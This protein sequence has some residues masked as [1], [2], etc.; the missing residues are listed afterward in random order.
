[1]STQEAEYDHQITN[2][3]PKPFLLDDLIQILY[4]YLTNRECIAFHLVNKSIKY[5]LRV[6]PKR[7]K[8]GNEIAWKKHVNPIRTLSNMVRYFPYSK[9]LVFTN[10]STE[11]IT[12]ED[13]IS[14]AS[15]YPDV[16]ELI[17]GNCKIPYVTNLHE[18]VSTY[19]PTRNNRRR[20]ED[21]NANTHN[22]DFHYNA[23]RNAFVQDSQI[24]VTFAKRMKHLQ[25]LTLMNIGGDITS[26][27]SVLVLSCTR[28]R[29]LKLGNDLLRCECGWEMLAKAFCA[30]RVLEKFSFDGHIFHHQ[31]RD[32]PLEFDL[33]DD[34]TNIK[35]L[36]IGGRLTS[37]MI[38]DAAT[39]FHNLTHLCLGRVSDMTIRALID[40]YDGFDVNLISLSLTARLSPSLSLPMIVNF[41][42]T[43]KKLRSFSGYKFQS[44]NHHLINALTSL[45]ETV[46]NEGNGLEELR[47]TDYSNWNSGQPTD[48]TKRRMLSSF[49][50]LHSFAFMNLSDE[51]LCH[52][53]ENCKLIQTLI[54]QNSQRVTDKSSKSI[55]SFKKLNNLGLTKT[56][57]TC[58]GEIELLKHI[59]TKLKTLQITNYEDEKFN[60]NDLIQIFNYCNNAVEMGIKSITLSLKCSE[61]IGKMAYGIQK[62]LQ[63]LKLGVCSMECLQSFKE[64]LPAVLVHALV[65]EED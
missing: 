7:E 45:K 44:V 18:D 19:S 9:K 8:Y 11:D 10:F 51:L 59:G 29:S 27:L 39:I 17:F 20:I 41:L 56:N 48:L 63:V 30:F 47:L 15:L 5:N 53:S 54:I 40:V 36:S 52:L 46:E 26:A 14:I 21:N 32:T 64:A 35:S 34:V 33:S 4:S 50:N 12:Y 22:Y 37:R 24:I 16:Q 1:M 49:S 13:S 6:L 2:A 23:E 58:D 60:D 43:C 31:A 55:K 65:L 62:T 42:K 3:T 57:M 38:R 61:M 25:V 28:L